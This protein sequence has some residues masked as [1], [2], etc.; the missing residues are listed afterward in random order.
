MVKHSM[1][2]LELLRKRGI[3]GDVDFLREALRVLVDGIMDAEVS[4]QIGAQHGERSPERV[5]YR[6]G[7]RN[8]TWDIRVGTM[9]LHIPKLREGSYF[10]SLLEPRRRSEKALLSVIQQA[11]V[12]GV[13]TRRVDDL[14]K[15]LG[16]DG[17]SSSQVSR[18]CE[19]LDEVVESFLGRP[20]D[21]GPYPYVWLDGL[22]QKVREG[23]RIVNVCVVVATGVNADGQREIL[24]MDVGASE[25]GAFWL[26]FLRS[27][28]ARGLSGV[29]LATSDAHQGLK[30]A[31]AAVF[32]GA[33]WQRCRTHFMANLLT[34]VPKRAQPGVAT[35]VRT[36]YQQ[37]SPAEVHGQLDRVV[38]FV[39]RHVQYPFAHVDPCR[40]LVHL[41]PPWSWC[42]NGGAGTLHTCIVGPN[43]RVSVR[44]SPV[45]Y[46]RGVLLRDGA[47]KLSRPAHLMTDDAPLPPTPQIGPFAG[48]LQHTNDRRVRHFDGYSMI[49]RQAQDERGAHPH[50]SPLPSRERG[51]DSDM[52][53]LDFG[54]WDGTGLPRR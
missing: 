5:T 30:N 36:I 10:P 17:I 24:G 40:R 8:R 51:A 29:E 39:H 32:A 14:I 25:D 22:T 18:I 43:T 1:D 19:Q 35:M 3:D 20:L 9:E 16:C 13:S 4:A 6:N 31:I 23:G 34:R 12:E 2:L 50:P 21:G 54:V 38:V 49:L 48:H 37:L 33:S 27:L 41:S 11:Y 15:A 47:T 26:A 45:P 46:G 7:Y 42:D 28:T 52:D 53:G 44:S